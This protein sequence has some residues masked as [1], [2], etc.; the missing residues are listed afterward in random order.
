[1]DELIYIYHVIYE[2][3]TSSFL[4]KFPVFLFSD[5]K[6]LSGKLENIVHEVLKYQKLRMKMTLT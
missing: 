1:M 6:F 2:L 5:V 4:C 3:V